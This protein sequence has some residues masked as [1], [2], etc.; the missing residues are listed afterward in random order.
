MG[1]DLVHLKDI[2]KSFSGV[3]V[4]HGVDLTLGSGEVLALLGENGAGK[5]T[6]VKIL[7]GDIPPT[8]GTIVIDGTEVARLDVFHARQLGV[9]MIFQEL[10]DAPTLTV[11]ENIFLGQLPGKG[12]FVSWTEMKKK[13]Q[14][15]LDRLQVQIPVDSLAGSLR[16]GERQLLEI[17]RALTQN[18][19]VLVLDEPTAALSS[20][21]V[22]RLF[23]VMDQLK[24]QG[25]GMIYITHRL[26]EVARVADRVQVLRDGNSVLTVKN[27][28]VER[29]A[30]VT[31]M[32]GQEAEKNARPVSIST[33]KSVLEIKN[34][35]SGSEYSDISLTVK[36]GEVVCLFGKI[37]SGTS[38][39]LESI[40]GLRPISS[41]GIE[42]FNEKFI[43]K[44]PAESANFGIGYLPADRQRLGSFG[45]RSVAENLAVTC[46]KKMSTLG[47][48][49]QALEFAAFDRWAEALRI[50]SRSGATQ[51]IATLSG[52][53][54]QKVLLARWFEA[55]V[56]VLLL[57]EPT[58]GVDVGARRD[59]YNI[60]RR[61]A[62]ERNMAILVATS[63]YEEVVLLAD[64]ALVLARGKIVLELSGDSVDSKSLVSASS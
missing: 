4:L 14:E 56:R 48:V 1:Q 62:K 27:S 22:D 38:G 31:A 35:S 8:S 10:N 25:V 49:K 28:E 53:N 30:L 41:G 32:L 16:V 20:I 13:S 55:N 21:E 24:S 39:I 19:K 64:R 57:V 11:A 15:I 51:E 43:P 5:S 59:I 2:R 60:I 61:Q 42:I 46:W 34:L 47:F 54:Q 9:R 44:N 40:F 18:A 6:L 36:A 12:G 63:D 17:A 58:R 3:E 45:I 37:G 23:T 29:S 33:S 50:S 26:D 52:G 7:A